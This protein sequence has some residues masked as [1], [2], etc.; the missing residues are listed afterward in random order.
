MTAA[1]YE[2]KII[3]VESNGDYS[4]LSPE[5]FT[6]RAKTAMEMAMAEAAVLQ[7]GYVG[8]EH[9][10]I[11]VLRDESSVAVRLLAS[12]GARP[13]ELAADIAKAI[14]A[15]P[16][17]AAAGLERGG[18]SAAAKG[19]GKTPTLD[20]FGRD[21]TKLAREGKIDPVIGRSSEIE[22]GHSNSLPPHQK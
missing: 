1:Q 4:R 3:E 10:L 15:A 8:T 22:P 18:K 14:G 20:Q 19:D 2:E 9:I 7:H 12:L 6:P 17:Q 5:D 16:A 13:D 21:L 11:A